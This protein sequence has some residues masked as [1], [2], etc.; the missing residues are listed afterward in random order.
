M[1][2]AWSMSI[3]RLEEFIS[4]IM[5]CY[6]GRPDREDKFNRYAEHGRDERIV[7]ARCHHE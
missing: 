6:P 7:Q 5:E 4:L 2:V 1:P 3:H